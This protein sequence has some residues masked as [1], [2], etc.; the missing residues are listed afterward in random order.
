MWQNGHWVSPEQLDPLD[1]FDGDYFQIK[2]A[3]NLDSQECHPE[4]VETSDLHDQVAT[5]Q[6]TIQTTFR[7]L[8]GATPECIRVCSRPEFGDHREIPRTPLDLGERADFDRLAEARLNMLTASNQSDEQA[9]VLFHTWFLSGLGFHRCTASRPVW[10]GEDRS[11]WIQEIQQVWGHR[12]DQ[13]RIIVVDPPVEPPEDGGHIFSH[14][15]R[16]CT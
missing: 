11:G 16:T 1:V 9:R 8:D 6:S 14:S 7:T 15:T 3:L 5:L 10:L 2:I 13:F 4:A 12:I